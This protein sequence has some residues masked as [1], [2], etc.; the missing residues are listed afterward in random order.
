MCDPIK[1]PWKRDYKY[2][3]PG[4]HRYTIGI[5]LDVYGVDL[6]Q[7]RKRANYARD[8]CELVQEDQIWTSVMGFMI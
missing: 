3:Q 1:Y 5:V 2:K 7:Y 6:W 8:E 4:S